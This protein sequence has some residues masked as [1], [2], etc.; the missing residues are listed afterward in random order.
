ME[1]EYIITIINYGTKVNTKMDRDKV[2]EQFIIAITLLHIRANL[3]LDF[4]TAK[5]LL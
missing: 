1:M 4:Q 2:S 5:V 3:K